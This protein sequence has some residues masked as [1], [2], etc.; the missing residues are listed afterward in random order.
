RRARIHLEAYE[1]QARD[2]TGGGDLCTQPFTDELLDPLAHHL[3]LVG[4]LGRRHVHDVHPIRVDVERRACHE[5]VTA[6]VVSQMSLPELS[7]PSALG[8]DGSSSVDAALIL[9]EV[10]DIHQRWSLRS[11]FCRAAVVVDSK[12]TAGGARW[13]RQRLI[14]C[15]ERN[16]ARK[17]LLPG[18]GP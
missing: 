15:L 3:T 4:A 18:V 9:P 14:R 17:Q 8:L 16:A 6:I 1:L 5:A 2:E 10:G 11:A 13:L 12:L 7:I